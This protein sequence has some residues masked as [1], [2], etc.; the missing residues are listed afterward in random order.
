ML[1]DIN[2]AVNIDELIKSV[3]KAVNI[4]ELVKTAEA[5]DINEL[6]RLIDEN[7]PFDGL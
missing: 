5:V 4:D 1:S 3:E 6:L 7:N 2:E